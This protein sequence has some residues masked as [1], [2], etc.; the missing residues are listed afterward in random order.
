MA[1]AN[2]ANSTDMI[3]LRDALALALEALGSA[4]LAKERLRKWLAAGELPWSC[5]EWKGLDAEGLA[6]KRREQLN[7]ER[8][9]VKR[10]VGRVI[11]SLPSAAYYSGDP[12]FW[13]ATL[14]IDWEDN[15][16]A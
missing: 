15:G 5:M 11:Y 1:K 9:A 7:A 10:G 2:D 12:R 3:W 8:L 13:S 14:G 4:A 16:A 6:Q